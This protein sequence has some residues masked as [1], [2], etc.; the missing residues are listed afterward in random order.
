[1]S[2]LDA[3]DFEM[4]LYAKVQAQAKEIAALSASLEREKAEKE[5]WRALA[6]AHRQDSE[7]VDRYVARL[8]ASR[9]GIE[10][11]VAEGYVQHKAGCPKLSQR[12]M[13]SGFPESR[14]ATCDCGLT[15]R[16]SVLLDRP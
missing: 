5:Q 4:D 6:E 15:D 11:L 1:M 13:L 12:V 14:S 8:D 9:E 2:I 16:L 3:S 7:D 10:A